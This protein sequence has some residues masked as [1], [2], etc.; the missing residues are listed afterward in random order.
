MLTDVKGV[1][2]LCLNRLTNGPY[3]TSGFDF[4]LG[5]YIALPAICQQE[6]CNF[7]VYFLSGARSMYGRF[8]ALWTTAY[9]SW[10]KSGGASVSPF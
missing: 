1:R 6:I 8:Q 5:Y 4:R 3:F 10:E 9:I 7:S 2:G